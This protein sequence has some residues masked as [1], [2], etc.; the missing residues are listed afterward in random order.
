L[1]VSGG[2]RAATA[3]VA[4]AVSGVGCQVSNSSTLFFI[5]YYRLHTQGIAGLNNPDCNP[6]WWIG[7]GLTVHIQNWILDWDCQSSFF[8]SI[9]IQ[10]NHNFYP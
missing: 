4:S 7:L 10:K 6:I 2:V 3:A 9:Q 8:T 5:L 1:F